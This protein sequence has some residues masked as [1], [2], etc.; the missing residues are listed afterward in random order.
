MRL[1]SVQE[2]GC[3]TLSCYRFFWTE[4][5]VKLEIKEVGGMNK[6][7]REQGAGGATERAELRPLPKATEAGAVPIQTTARS[8]AGASSANKRWSCGFCGESQNPH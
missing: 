2:I 8:G 7:D 5:W 6:E 1:N 3:D 4:N